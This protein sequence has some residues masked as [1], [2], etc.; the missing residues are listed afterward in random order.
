MDF[1]REFNHVG[2]EG[3]VDFKN[4]KKPI[5]FLMKI[6]QIGGLKSKENAVVL[7]F[8]GGS[9]STAHALMAFNDI[10]SGNRQAIICQKNK[11]VKINVVDKVTLP[12]MKN[13]IEGYTINRREEFVL[14]EIKLN[15]INIIKAAEIM[16]NLEKRKVET[17]ELS[18]YDE[19]KIEFIDQSIK[20]IGFRK[21]STEFEGYH[22]NLRYFDIDFV[23]AE[24]NPDQLK[25]DMARNSLGL[26]SIKN[27]VYDL[28][29]ETESYI[30]LKTQ[31]KVIALYH[32]KFGTEFE[33]F[34]S[35]LKVF[36]CGKIVYIFGPNQFGIDKDEF[37][38]IDAEI[39]II[40]SDML[41][42]FQEV[43]SLRK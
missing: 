40:P 21:K 2:Y 5:A 41:E 31:E 4:G 39:E 27:D 25:Y 11:E 17:E 19:V 15:K 36:D 43:K 33:K 6:F 24:I 38:L 8:F 14:E 28:Y 26:L 35:E 9:G 18:L 10:Y 13:I 20:L 22:A 23:R 37:D 16:D 34:V 42:A 29:K 30:I 3:G 1:E 12:R 7:D 32:E